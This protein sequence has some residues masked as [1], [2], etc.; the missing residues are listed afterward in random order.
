MEDATKQE[1]TWMFAITFVYS[2]LFRVS[3]PFT[4]WR[5]KAMKSSSC[6]LLLNYQL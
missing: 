3:F 5:C 6:R 1:K 2:S 4:I